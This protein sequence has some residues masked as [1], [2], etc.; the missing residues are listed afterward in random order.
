LDVA[1]EGINVF[2]YCVPMD[3][4]ESDGTLEWD[5]T[6]LVLVGLRGGGRQGLG[7]TC[8]AA[9]AAE[10]IRGT[11]ADLVQGHD[12]L[13][14]PHLWFAL[15]AAV[16]NYGQAGIASA[17]ILQLPLGQLVGRLRNTIPAD[18]LS[19]P[20]QIPADTDF[21]SLIP[22]LDSRRRT[23]NPIDAYHSTLLS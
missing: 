4:P 11:L 20:E 12:A 17:A 2:V 8:T 22:R 10:L 7:Y 13:D 3:F 19:D 18:E 15:N 14:I 1:I 5:A 23:P 21:A 6:T 16:R 9:S